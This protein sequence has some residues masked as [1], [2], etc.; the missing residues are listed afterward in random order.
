[1]PDEV[2][3]EAAHQIGKN[4]CE[5]HLQGR[6]EFVLTTHV[7]KDHIRNHILF[8]AVLYVLFLY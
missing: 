3:L 6:H 2:S 1:M 7:D 8:N 5:K 4:L